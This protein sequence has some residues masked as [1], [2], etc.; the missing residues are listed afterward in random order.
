MFDTG[1]TTSVISEKFFNSL[2]EKVKYHKK[3]LNLSLG[4]ALAGSTTK[5]RYAIPLLLAL[6]ESFQDKHPIIFAHTFYVCPGLSREMYIGS[7]LACN[8]NFKVSD[9]GSQISVK[10][11]ENYLFKVDPLNISGLKTIDLI[12]YASSENTILNISSF[13]LNPF[14]TKIVKT[15]IKDHTLQDTPVKIFSLNNADA[16]DSDLPIFNTPYVPNSIEPV[17]NNLEINI[18]VQNRGELPL[19]VREN[20]IIANYSLLDTTEDLTCNSLEA[21][22]T[23]NYYKNFTA[24]SMKCEDE[25]YC[26]F[27]QTAFVENMPEADLIDRDM[28]VDKLHEKRKLKSDYT[29]QEFLEMFNWEEMSPYIQERL[30]PIVIK[31]REAFAHFKM[32]IGKAKYFKHHINLIGKP[33]LPKQRPFNQKTLPQVKDAIENFITYDIMSRGEYCQHYSNLVPIRKPNGNI[34]LCVDLI[35]LNKHVK[36]SDKI[37]TM[38]SPELVMQKFFGKKHIWTLDM[39]DAYFHL[40]ASDFTKKFYGIYS[41][42]NQDSLRFVRMIQGEKSSIFGFLRTMN[43]MLG[44][45]HENVDYWLDDVC[46]FGDTVEEMISIFD[47]VVSILHENGF[48]ISPQKLCVDKKTLTYLGFDINKNQGCKQVME[49][50]IQ[51]ILNTPVPISYKSLIS[52][53]A[54]I[55]YYSSHIPNFAAAS[56][57]LR[58]LVR[59]QKNKKPFKWNEVLQQSFLNTKAAVSQHI[60]TYFPDY[61]G[62]F[63][64]YCDASYFYYSGILYNIR[65]NGDKKVVAVLSSPFKEANLGWNIFTKE[66]YAIIY[67]CI[68]FQDIFQ[69]SKCVLLSDAKSLLY[70]SQAKTDHSVMY[71][72]A[73]YLSSLNLE[74][75][76]VKG[77]DN[78]ADF[79]SRPYEAYLSQ[80]KKV[81]AKSLSQIAKEVTEMPVKEYYTKEEIRKLLTENQTNCSPDVDRITLCKQKE[82]EINNSFSIQKPVIKAGCC[83]ECVVEISQLDNNVNDFIKGINQKKEIILAKL[84]KSQKVCPNE[85][86]KD[87]NLSID[88][89]HYDS[90]DH[91]SQNFISG[92]IHMLDIHD[93]YFEKVDL[94]ESLPFEW[95]NEDLPENDDLVEICQVNY[96]ED[97]DYSKLLTST[98]DAPHW[99]HD[100]L[101]HMP[102]DEDC[103]IPETIKNMSDCPEVS[104]LNTVTLN[105]SQNEIN[106]SDKN[107]EQQENT[108]VDP[109][110]K[111]K[112][113]VIRTGILSKNQFIRHQNDDTNIVQIKEHLNSNKSKHKQ[114]YAKKFIII[115]GILFKMFTKDLEKE[116]NQSIIKLPR[117]YIPNQLIPFFLNKYHKDA[118]FQTEIMT[119]TLMQKYYFPNMQEKIKEYCNSCRV[120]AY[121]KKDTLPP[122]IVGKS[123]IALG[124]FE[125]IAMD[126]AINLPKSKNGYIHILLI[127]DCWSRF[128]FLA[129]LK[130]KTSKEI[131]DQFCRVY[132]HIGGY[133]ELVIAD[134]EKGIQKG[135]F[136]EHLTKMGTTFKPLLP[137]RPQSAG[138]IEAQVGRTKRCLSALTIEEGTRENWDLHLHRVSFLLNN[139]EFSSTK[140]T[141]FE[142]L[143]GFKKS[144]KNSDIIRIDPLSEIGDNEDFSKLFRNKQSI[145]NDHVQQYD[146]K[147]KDKNSKLLNK[148]TIERQFQV[149]DKV[150]RKVHSHS[151]GPL[152]NR[153]LLGKYV[154]PFTVTKVNQFSLDLIEDQSGNPCTDHKT[155]CKKFNPSKDDFDL[156]NSFTDELDK[157][158][159][160]QRTMITR[161]MK[162]K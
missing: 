113:I 134:N 45:L 50:K 27:I 157:I 125:N 32:D 128:L 70:C 146:Q 115:Q 92:N 36:V 129:P 55:Q 114:K 58:C 144:N 105:N 130:S 6:G 4:T 96:N 136:Y 104:H 13:T 97:N 18:V 147:S 51:G 71:R 107:Q 141:P 47:K 43:V 29:E 37:V 156:P 69:Y 121:I 140:L 14:E 3:P 5:I 159:E 78:M 111:M 98:F 150:M 21:Y 119:K 155:Y 138:Q 30:K 109:I 10:L 131:L 117:I 149:G 139:S 137:Y 81:Q 73:M 161:S 48:T 142:T 17:D 148:H 75:K 33:T 118:H 9:N 22:H 122:E 38:G 25:N 31:Y 160:N 24:N 49:S 19:E 62:S 133:P 40:E 153:A 79:Y 94:N 8:P 154:G 53:L 11:P 77:S 60:V 72:L 89:Y 120:C 100:T 2:P 108:F 87:N 44:P 46:M 68:K 16:Y 65:Q 61:N 39:A 110:D 76:H 106:I 127:L 64:L 123:R 99:A 103:L 162:Q 145:I 101:E 15:K 12:F 126:L 7:D 41:Y 23:H 67:C 91:K 56:I 20:Q 84:F 143:F 86:K 26:Q 88:L 135:E 35:A 34:R 59:E 151:Q 132:T 28:P 124:P 57:P 152:V 95:G 1:C 116:V 54:Q 82:N 66:L 112:A 83:D 93:Q 158:H 90:I 52:F 102:R 74:F 63:E 80:F 85:S 42:R